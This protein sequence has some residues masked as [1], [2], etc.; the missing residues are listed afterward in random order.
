[1]KQCCPRCGYLTRDGWSDGWNRAWD[2]W[3]ET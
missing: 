1:M 2:H 3:D